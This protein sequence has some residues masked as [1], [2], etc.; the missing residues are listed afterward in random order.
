MSIL[1][2][3]KFETTLGIATLLVSIA[4]VAVSVSTSRQN[5]RLALQGQIGDQMSRYLVE[6]Q[7]SITTGPSPF[8]VEGYK[9]LGGAGRSRIIILHGL[10][11]GLIDLMFQNN[12]PRANVWATYIKGIP[13]PLLEG[14]IE[15]VYST[16]KLTKAAVRNARADV[17]ATLTK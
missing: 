15:E 12:D 6:Y 1:G 4:A 5:T 14:R 8:T 13:G 11:I 2:S 7:K 17:L 10:Q 9:N 16:H 3:I